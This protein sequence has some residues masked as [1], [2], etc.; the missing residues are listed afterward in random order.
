MDDLEELKI[1]VAYKKNGVELDYF[2]GTEPLNLLLKV[3][4]CWELGNDKHKVKMSHFF[5]SLFFEF[6]FYISQC[7]WLDAR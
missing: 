3:A 2:P 6:L 4:Q 1:G 7:P 5:F